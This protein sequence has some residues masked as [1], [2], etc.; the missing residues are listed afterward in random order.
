M[1]ANGKLVMYG[2]AAAAAW[3]FFY[4]HSTTVCSIRKDEQGFIHTTCGRH[5]NY[6]AQVILDVEPGSFID[7]ATHQERID[8]H[9]QELIGQGK[10]PPITLR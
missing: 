8:K 9:N 5:R 10:T 2:V 4:T 6:E 7:N 1:T 3:Y